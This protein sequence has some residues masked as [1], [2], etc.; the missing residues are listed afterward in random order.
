MK[1]YK[2]F[3]KDMTCHGFP[4][5]D[6]GTYAKREAQSFAIAVFTPAKHRWM[7]LNTIRPYHPYIAR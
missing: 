2:G 7:C 6:G 4:F 1:A 3:N 5:E